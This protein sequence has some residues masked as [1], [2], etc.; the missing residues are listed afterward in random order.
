MPPRTLAPVSQNL[1]RGDLARCPRT[2]KERREVFLPQLL[3]GQAFQLTPAAQPFPRLAFLRRYGRHID[4]LE[5]KVIRPLVQS[6]RPLFPNA[7]SLHLGTRYTEQD[8]AAL[9]PWIWH[10]PRVQLLQLQKIK[11]SQGAAAPD[12]TLLSTPQSLTELRVD[13]S[14]A[15]ASLEMLFDNLHT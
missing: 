9:L 12:W 11:V 10:C 6:G 2:S 1:D 14:L 5:C 7:Q 13:A 3:L 8:L 4:H 15:T